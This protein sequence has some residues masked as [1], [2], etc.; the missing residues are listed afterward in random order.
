MADIILAE[1]NG[2]AWLVGGVEHID[3]MLANTLP[4]DVSIEIVLCESDSQINELWERF[5]GEPEPGSMPWAIH[6]GVV[7]RIRRQSTGHSVFFEQWSA[8]LDRDAM[9]VIRGASN[10]ALQFEEAEVHLVSYAPGTPGRAARDLA[11]L[12]SGLIEEELE[13]LGIAETRFVRVSRDSSTL[14]AVGEES[15]R[16]DIEI[17]ST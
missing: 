1:Y 16:I 13:K 6:P 10:W 7:K 17:K 2:Q 5:C 14:P 11:N 12:R 15:Q 9:E 3:D 4:D 8:Q